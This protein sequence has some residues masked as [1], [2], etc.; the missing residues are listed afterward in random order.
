MA[1]PDGSH[2]VAGNVLVAW[3]K[4]SHE[5][6]V[7]QHVSTHFLVTHMSFSISIILFLH[8]FHHHLE[9]TRLSLIN[10]IIGITLSIVRV[11]MGAVSH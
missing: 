2:R 6:V 3:T 9:T 4:T 5:L 1:P 8:D 11:Q 10:L 7:C